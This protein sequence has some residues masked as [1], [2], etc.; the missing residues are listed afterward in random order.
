M[1]FRWT[2]EKIFVTDLFVRKLTKIVR[3]EMFWFEKR[4]CPAMSKLPMPWR[5]DRTVYKNPRYPRTNKSNDQE[6]Q[7]NLG[8]SPR[9]EHREGAT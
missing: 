8:N 4:K 1:E 5:L 2:N 6:L 9:K 7:Q 3:A